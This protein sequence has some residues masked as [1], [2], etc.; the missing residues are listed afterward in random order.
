VSEDLSV[1]TRPV[2][3][4]DAVVAYGRDPDQIADVRFGDER[5]VKRPLI[6]I[7]HGGFW[8]PK[9]DRAHTGPM[10]MALAAAGWT[11]ASIEYRRI[12]GTPDA[13]IADVM[14]AL[15]TLPSLVAQHNGDVIAIG[16]SAGGHLVLLAA[17]S[18]P[19]S[20]LRGVLA[21]A[22]AADL[23]LAHERRLSDAAVM[24]FLGTEPQNRSDLDPRRLRA[25]SVAT[26]LIHGEDD[27][28]VPIEISESYLAAHPKVRS[29]RLEGQGHFAVIDPLSGAWATVIAELQR[30]SEGVR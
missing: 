23:C 17:A 25:P 6:M 16:H 8:R 7:V 19:T 13:T 4:P 2:S 5:A 30:L 24:A 11:V 10:A 22:P 26:T 28:V 20:K 27:E 9:Y 15:D 18:P 3:P 14:R 29:I 21:L 1:M 12:P